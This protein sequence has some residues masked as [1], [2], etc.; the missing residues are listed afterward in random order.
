MTDADNLDHVK[1][2]DMTMLDD[3]SWTVPTPNE[4]EAPLEEESAEVRLEQFRRS[5]E[6]VPIDVAELEG[7]ANDLIRQGYERGR[8][9][10]RKEPEVWTAADELSAVKYAQERGYITDLEAQRKVRKLLRLK[11]KRV[12]AVKRRRATRR[13]R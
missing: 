13:A 4:A 12:L 7:F 1:E 8:T 10:V 6:I 2:D 5:H 11:G 9:K 3:P